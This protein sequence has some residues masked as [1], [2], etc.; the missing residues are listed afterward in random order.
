MKPN[1][2][3][4][5]AIQT[6]K[7]AAWQNRWP[8]AALWLFGVALIAGYYWFEP[9]RS[10]LERIGE[11]KTRYGILFG[12]V[13]TAIFGG[14]IPS[15]LRVAVDRKVPQ[16][17]WGLLI[18]NVIFWAFKGA[19]IDLFYRFQAWMFGDDSSVKTI[20][21]KVS[22]DALRYGPLMGL[23]NCVLFYIWQDNGYSFSQT[24]TALGRNWYVRKVLPALISNWCVWLP[25]A[26]M[27]YS[28]PLALQLPVQNLILCFWVLVLVFFTTTIED[29]AAE[30]IA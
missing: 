30:S 27:I 15:I 9:I 2:A 24:R 10:G 7:Q 20:A 16:A 1:S 11:V 29:E 12:I 14:L 17:F 4:A 25:S 21:S 28:L 6:G 19:E 23:L 13:S 5:T 8:G 22:F 26:I 18:A 3:L